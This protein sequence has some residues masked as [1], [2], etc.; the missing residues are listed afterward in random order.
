LTSRSLADF[1]SWLAYYEVLKKS[2]T[3]MPIY[4]TNSQCGAG[5]FALE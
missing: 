4:T 5:E 2:P 1:D 3:Y